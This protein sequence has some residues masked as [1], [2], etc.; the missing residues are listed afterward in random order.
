MSE[1]QQDSSQLSV[2]L[3][4]ED[5]LDRDPMA[6]LVPAEYRLTMVHTELEAAALAFAQAQPDVLLLAINDLDASAS[7]RNELLRKCNVPEDAAP[8]AV[9][10]CLNRHS[11]Q[12]G[13]LC[14]RGVFDDFATVKPA[15]HTER[16]RLALRRAKITKQGRQDLL[17]VRA[18]VEAA[19]GRFET[20]AIVQREL[21]GEMQRLRSRL[22]Q[23]AGPKSVLATL[24]ERIARIAAQ[25]RMAC[26]VATKRVLVVDD[27]EMMREVLGAT[28]ES[29]GYEVRYAA[30][31]E[32]AV[33]QLIT[34]RVSLVLMDL[35]MPGLDGIAAT[36]EIRA[37][38]NCRSVPIIVVSGHGNRDSVRSSRAVGANDFL[39]KP[40]DQ[41]RL[42]EKV[43]RYLDA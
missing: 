21:H 22:L 31:A 18:R 14:M 37:L 30:S 3:V 36:R 13:D 24:C 41:D 16:I 15:P 28:L 27:D 32:Q 1:Q 5:A 23:D 29:G 43:R 9:A 17:D 40:V 33:E 34:Q 6:K 19:R 10:L 42:L 25:G 39:V 38:P 26:Q 20:L 8:L 7:F 12:A 35:M 4:A 2:L 11:I